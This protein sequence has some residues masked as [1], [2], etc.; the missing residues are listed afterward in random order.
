[1]TLVGK[2]ASSLQLP[3]RGVDWSILFALTVMR[4]AAGDEKNRTEMQRGGHETEGV[5]RQELV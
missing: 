2:L 4:I 1:M 3:S 5:R